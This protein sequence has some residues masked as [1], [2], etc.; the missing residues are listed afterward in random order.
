MLNA[1]KK[2]FEQNLSPEQTGDDEH[3]LK[4]ATAALL[5]EMM[6]QDGKTTDDEILAVKS[7]LQSKFGLTESETHTLFDLARE[8]TRQAVD[9]YQFTRLINDQFSPEKKIK[10]IEYLW[11]IAYSD[12]HLDA[13]EEHMIRRIA[14]LLYVSHKDM[15]K[16]K[17]KVQ[18]AQEN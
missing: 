6:Q 4:L 17:H 5:I 13:H 15:M 7:A 12:N 9:F 11:G 2:F 18:A 14:D 3:A 16:T 8:E 1:I 10:V